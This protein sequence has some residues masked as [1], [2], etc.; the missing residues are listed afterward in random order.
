VN[1]NN[2]EMRTEEDNIKYLRATFGLMEDK[3][4]EIK[5]LENQVFDIGRLINSFGEFIKV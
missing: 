5:E 4:H 3:N 2:G 1:R